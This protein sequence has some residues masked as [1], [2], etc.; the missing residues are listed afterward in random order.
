[1]PNDLILANCTLI[2]GTGAPPRPA[3][4]IAVDAGRI[5]GI[6]PARADRAAAGVIDLTGTWVIPGL[7]NCHDHLYSRNALRRTRPGMGLAA[8]RRELDARSD[9]QLLATMAYNAVQEL[10]QGITTTRDMGVRNH[11][12]I[13]LR[14]AIEAGLLPGPTV[15]ACG[16]PIAMTGGHVWTFSREADGPDECAKAVREQ[17]KKGADVIKVMAS[18]GLSNYPDEKPQACHLSLAELR[19]ITTVAHEHSRKVCA[20]AMANRAIRNCIEA[21]IDSIE[22]GVYLDEDSAQIMGEK[23][24]T[25]VPTFANVARVADPEYNATAGMPGRAEELRTGVLEP[26]AESVRMAIAA[27][28]M[29]GVGTDSAG[30]YIDELTML[31]DLGM[32]PME[33]LVV[34]TSNGARLCDL[35]DRLGTVETGKQADLVA[36]AAD[37]L[38]D[39]RNVGRVSL[40]VKNGTVVRRDDLLLQAVPPRA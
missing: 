27:G 9:F 39:I 13:E 30:H 33:A 4:D 5:T 23:G 16:M 32:S 14:R 40:V 28:V 18:G 36:L 8:L 10:F 22:H 12:N 24:I 15:L 26:H 7:I 25:L 1:M 17:L 3:V 31:C 37:P 35:S 11:L 2:D 20:H 29:I 21:N 6:E 38:A 34:A 19:A